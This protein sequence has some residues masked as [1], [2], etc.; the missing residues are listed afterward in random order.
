M[1]VRKIPGRLL[2]IKDN[3]GS[4]GTNEGHHTKPPS[5]SNMGS[6]SSKP[7][8][9]PP[10]VWKGS[11]PTSVS[12]DL[13]E[14]LQTS[15][16]TDISRA[17]T[18]ELH[19]QARVAE[20]LKRLQ[21]EEAARLKELQDKISATKEQEHQRAGD[22][23][24]AAPEGDALK[25]RQSVVREVEALRARLESRHKLREVPDTVVTARSEVVRC[26]REH[27]RRPLD[28]WREVERF[29]DEVRK[30]EESWVEKVA[31]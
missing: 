19:I 3:S 2:V 28:C 13:V 5:R 4:C 6:S 22:D 12:Q 31:S 10:Y 15:H 9:S 26:L 14:S 20:E 7:S 21:A 24:P 25:S 29:K 16:E 23:Q 17:Q 8:G 18:L 30:L 1:S 27:D 11:S